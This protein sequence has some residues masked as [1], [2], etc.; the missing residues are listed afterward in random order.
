VTGSRDHLEQAG[1]PFTRDLL[2]TAHLY[3]LP[4]G[5]RRAWHDLLTRYRQ[6]AGSDGN[7]I[8]PAARRRPGRSTRS[9]ADPVSGTQGRKT[10]AGDACQALA[11][12]RR[13]S[14]QL[15]RAGC[16]PSSCAIR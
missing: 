13:W 9:S 14:R 3:H 6:H 4:A 8:S 10:R 16:E 7:R 1:F 5:A 2:G 15:T 11:G 12:Q